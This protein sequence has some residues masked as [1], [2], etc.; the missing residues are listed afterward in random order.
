[1][2]PSWIRGQEESMRV[3]TLIIGLLLGLLLFL[4]T[5]LLYGLSNAGNDE[6]NAGAAAIGVFVAL[7]WLV[8]SA[9]VMAFPLFSAIAFAAAALFAFLG[10]GSSDFKDLIIWGV[11]SAL[12]AVL[13]YFGWRGKRRDRREALAE[14]QRQ[15]DR[16]ARLEQLLTERR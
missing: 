6:K 2:M 8:A 15:M 1:M 10:G 14:R 4:Q 5:M 7:I 3:A 16:D 9:F 13:S 12:L 11:A